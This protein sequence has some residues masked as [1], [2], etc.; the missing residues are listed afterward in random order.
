MTCHEVAERL[1]AYVDGELDRVDAQL[2]S[3]H[4]ESCAVCRTLVEER[5]A[6][7]HLVRGLPYHRASPELQAAVYSAAVAPKPRRRVLA[8]AVAAAVVLLAVGIGG[9]NR[10]RS[11]REM[12]TLAEAVVDRHV[13]ALA[14]ARLI[15]VPSSDQHTVKPWFQG[16]LEFSPPVPDLSADGFVLLGGR[17]DRIDGRT[18]AALVYQR[19]LHVITV[20]VWPS[21]GH[22][23]TSDARTV[24]GFHER[25][26]SADG[27]SIWA[28]S[29]VNTSDLEA[30]RQAFQTAGHA[31]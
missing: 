31:P 8:W 20:F 4:V 16:K 3:D 18:V 9:L 6:L 12:T 13:S 26:W 17:T 29:D 24:R 7:R 14:A 30:F 11:D 1:D 5:E 21:D 22:L 19:R 23:A 25:H 28:V 15:D 10:W 27:M 2:V